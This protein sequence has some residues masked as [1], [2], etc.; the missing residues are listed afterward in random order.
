MWKPVIAAV[1]GM[2]LSM[3][4]CKRTESRTVS[5]VAE[6]TI[7]VLIIE[8]Q[9][10][11]ALRQIEAHPRLADQPDELGRTPL[12]AAVSRPIPAEFIE[13]LLTRDIDVNRRDKSG[14]T[15]LMMAAG[16]GDRTAVELLLKKGANATLADRQGVTALKRAARFQH[17]GVARLLMRHGAKPDIFD[18]AQLGLAK[19]LAAMLREEPSLARRQGEGGRTALLIAAFAGQNNGV[20]V[21]L[22][23]SRPLGACAAAATGEIEELKA[24]LANVAADTRDAATQM[25]P[26]ECAILG[27]RIEAAS[28]LLQRGADPDGID[29]DNDQSSPLLV[30]VRKGDKPMVELLLRHGADKTRFFPGFGTPHTVAL[31][32]NRPDIADLLR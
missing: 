19:E 8:R 1:L 29:L 13:T 24:A 7:T 21:L 2:L 25:A 27:G 16:T 23:Y 17:A 30:A 26:L 3:A 14:V 32:T 11:R 12:M 4:A 10:D 6:P 18:A 20:G 9:Y 5:S 31:R 28:L 22:P 15:A